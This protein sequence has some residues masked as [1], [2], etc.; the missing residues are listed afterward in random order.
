MAPANHPNPQS[1][2]A[3]P[4][5]LAQRDEDALGACGR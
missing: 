2:I 3:N 4:Q 1:P 5:P